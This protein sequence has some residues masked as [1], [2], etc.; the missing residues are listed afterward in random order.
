MSKLF[1]I[2]AKTELLSVSFKNMKKDYIQFFTKK[3]G[4]FKGL[5]K[6]YVPSEG[7]L[8]EPSR[9]EFRPVVTTVAEKL[10]YFE[11]NTSEYLDNL[12]SLEA[13]NASGIA[14]AELIVDG[15]SWGFLS[16][17]ELMRLKSLIEDQDFKNMYA[18]LPVREETKIWRAS[19]D[20]S[21]VWVDEL[22]KYQNTTTEKEQYILNDPNLAKIDG[23]K[24][25]PSIA[26]KETKKILGDGT[27]ENYSGEISHVE[28]A[29]I[30]V[31]LAKL[32]VAVLEA[33][34]KANDCVPIQSE[35][36]AQ[37]LFDYLHN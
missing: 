2:L 5:R 27:T 25:S 24:Y 15:V 11:E 29:K 4:A 31:N 7:A 23:A 9:R 35:M 19:A 28:R 16:S 26:V 17:L 1:T 22:Q 6:T 13:T 20:L 32:Q 37:K 3:Q 21:N 12:F 8:D 30:L 18:S 33:L 36:T 10:K 34:K 14:K